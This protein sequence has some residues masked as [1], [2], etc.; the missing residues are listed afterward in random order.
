[1]KNSVWVNV[2]VGIW[3]MIAPFALGAAGAAHA[4]TASDVV[5][6]ILLVAFS[7]WMLAAIA[8]PTGIAWFEMLCGIWL[9]VAPFVLG[10]SAAPRALWNDVVCGIIAIIVAIVAARA[11]VRPPR[12][13]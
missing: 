4:W 8:P 11:T 1:M 12:V 2:L 10:Y 13:A 7:W 9:I 5:L 6:G 3:L